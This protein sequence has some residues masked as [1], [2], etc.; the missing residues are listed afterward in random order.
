MKMQAGDLIS[1][2]FFLQVNITYKLQQKVEKHQ[3]KTLKMNIILYFK[4]FYKYFYVS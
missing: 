3:F 2:K 1:K 4:L